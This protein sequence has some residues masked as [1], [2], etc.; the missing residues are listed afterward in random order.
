MK[1]T[2]FYIVFCLLFISSYSQEK[3]ENV[4]VDDAI[5]EQ[6]KFDE[7]ALN[8]YKNLEDFNYNVIKDGPNFLERIWDWIT[9]YIK[10]FLSW[11]FDDISPANGVLR[12]ILNVLP[13]VIL[14]VLLYF[15]LKFFLRMNTKRMQDDD[16]DVKF[17]SIYATDDEKLINNKNLEQLIADAIEAKE[18]RLAIR[19]YYLFVLKKLSD[20]EMII[21]QQEKTNED[22]V[23]EISNENLKPDFTKT[24]RLYDF[25]WY[26][27]FE[28][29]E[30]QFK[31]AQ[32]LFKDLTRQIIG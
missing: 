26:G 7:N 22:Y 32:E 4:L 25:V 30:H 8:D 9:R 14:G 21:W 18:Y 2:I 31:K 3:I 12:F 27:N 24:T 29:T 10:Q 6:Q 17:A 16:D 13:Y 23:A 20:K 28:I 19:F 5:I 15:I 1:N 11:I